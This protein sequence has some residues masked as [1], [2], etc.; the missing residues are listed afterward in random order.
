[1]V[2]NNSII[3]LFVG[4]FVIWLYILIL[5]INVRKDIKKHRELVNEYKEKYSDDDIKEQA[6]NEC[7]ITEYHLDFNRDKLEFLTR[8][9][10]K[11]KI[12]VGI[13]VTNKDLFSQVESVDTTDVYKKEDKYTGRLVMVLN[14]EGNLNTITLE[15]F[16]IKACRFENQFGFKLI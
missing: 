13:E 2:E 4:L 14:I 11:N 16:S 8:L 1:M 10:E 15:K 12:M 7:L 3:Y 9:K 5:H 6:I